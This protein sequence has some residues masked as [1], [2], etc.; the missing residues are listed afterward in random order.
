MCGEGVFRKS[1]LRVF[2]VC[3]APTCVCVCVCVYVVC[4]V[5]VKSSSGTRYEVACGAKINRKKLRP[6]TVF[7]C[8]CV[9]IVVCVCVRSGVR[10]SLDMTTLTVMRLLPQKVCVC[11][12]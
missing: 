4:I 7:M 12:S 3:A 5:I 1:L 10:V 2:V 11:C 9:C 8:E 6:G